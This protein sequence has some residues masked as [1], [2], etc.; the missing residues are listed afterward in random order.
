MSLAERHKMSVD[1]VGPRGEECVSAVPRHPISRQVRI[2][3]RRAQVSWSASSGA[4]RIP[5]IRDIGHDERGH[6]EGGDVVLARCR[7]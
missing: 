2:P 7:R 5:G 4:G 1:P 3:R 6:G